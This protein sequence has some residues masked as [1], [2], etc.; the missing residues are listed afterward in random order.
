MRPFQLDLLFVCFFLF[1]QDSE[2]TELSVSAA[3]FSDALNTRLSQQVYS[4]L[5]SFPLNSGGP[6]SLCG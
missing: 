3:L 2:S 4:S 6:H 5:V 1:S